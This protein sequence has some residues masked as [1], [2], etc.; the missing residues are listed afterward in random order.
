MFHFDLGLRK[1]ILNYYVLFIVYIKIHLGEKETSMYEL[2]LIF[3]Q[4]KEQK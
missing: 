3:K 1:S 2:I 4:E